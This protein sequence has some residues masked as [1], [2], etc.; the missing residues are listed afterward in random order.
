MKENIDIDQQKI[1]Q[2]RN[3]RRGG[4][5][6]WTEWCLLPQTARLMKSFRP[7]YTETAQKHDNTHAG[8]VIALWT[9]CTPV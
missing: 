2:D 9:G 4:R 5:G 3:T 8:L 6:G 7:G 1:R